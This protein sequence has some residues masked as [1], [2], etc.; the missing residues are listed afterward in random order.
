[1]HFFV[2][3]NTESISC[4]WKDTL[5]V[6]N[7][8]CGLEINI[9]HP[10][11]YLILKFSLARMER[12]SQTFKPSVSSSGHIQRM[13]EKIPKSPHYFRH[14]THSF[15]YLRYI[16]DV[17]QYIFTKCNNTISHIHEC[18]VSTCT[19]SKP[20]ISNVKQRFLCAY[21]TSRNRIR[22]HGN[23]YTPP[24]R[25]LR[26]WLRWGVSSTLQPLYP[27]KNVPGTLRKGA[28][29]LRVGCRKSNPRSTNF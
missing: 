16:A 22:T 1:M 15:R 13:F 14:L 24:I 25:T 4:L 17:I 28:L 2:F 9:T 7:K 6:I 20:N 21:S 19:H 11:T 27:S 5:G 3:R 8:W 10:S 12:K 26:I 18:S 23:K 29:G